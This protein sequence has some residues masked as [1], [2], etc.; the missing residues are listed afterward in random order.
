MASIVDKV[1]HFVLYLDHD[2]NVAGLDWDDIVA[3]PIATLPKV[4]SPKKVP[5]VGRETAQTRRDESVFGQEAA[6]GD[7]GFGTEQEA[8]DSED[9]ASGSDSEEMCFAGITA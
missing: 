4:F 7:E 5:I 6:G 3:N 9:A 8:V 2:D 1:K